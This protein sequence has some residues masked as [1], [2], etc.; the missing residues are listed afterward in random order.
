[1]PY[2]A[3]A[4][5]SKQQQLKQHVNAINFYWCHRIECFYCFTMSQN[6]F[7][8][9]IKNIDYLIITCPLRAISFACSYF[10][11]PNSKINSLPS[12]LTSSSQTKQSKRAWIFSNKTHFMVHILNIFMADYSFSII[13]KHIWSI[14]GSYSI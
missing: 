4:T 11:L 10:L 9:P 5:T 1:M 14:Y 12:P 8:F 2:T 3:K 13:E 6:F 7:L